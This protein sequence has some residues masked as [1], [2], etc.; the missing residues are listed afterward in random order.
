M[1]GAE[2]YNT[3]YMNTAGQERK[4]EMTLFHVSSLMQRMKRIRTAMADFYSL[5]MLYLVQS[6]FLEM[7]RIRRDFSCAGHGLKSLKA[8]AVVENM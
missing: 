7:R 4:A 6:N 2:V 3:F 1:Y 8:N 5:E